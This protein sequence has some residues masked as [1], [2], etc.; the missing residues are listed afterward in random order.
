VNNENTVE[1]AIVKNDTAEGDFM[2]ALFNQQ[3]K[4][5]INY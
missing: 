2:L 1:S 5:I 4:R 3:D